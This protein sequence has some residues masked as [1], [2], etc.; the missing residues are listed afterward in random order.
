MK[1]LSTTDL[2][3]AK[4]RLVAQGYTVSGWAR[5]RGHSIVTVFSV[6]R[7]KRGI[8]RG[9]PKTDAVLQDLENEGFLKTK[10][11]HQEAA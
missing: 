6:L 4:E 7:G 5:A 3:R 11:Q 1:E 8:K 10:R 2:K 9:G